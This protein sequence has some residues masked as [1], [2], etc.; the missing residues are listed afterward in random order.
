GQAVSTGAALALTPEIKSGR[1]NRLYV[2]ALGD[3]TRRAAGNGAG[4][5]AAV[6]VITNGANPPAS[7]RR[8]DADAG[9]GAPFADA[10]FTAEQVDTGR[11]LYT[12][13]QC[14]ICH[15]ANLQG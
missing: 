1:D 14:Q 9:A 11:R 10:R 15:G 2:F 3:G 12:E 8:G 13:Q 7:C 6:G 4:A 5:N